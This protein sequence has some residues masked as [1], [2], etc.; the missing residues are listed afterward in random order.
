MPVIRCGKRKEKKCKE[1][2]ECF[3][4]GTTCINNKKVI[5]K[6]P[7]SIIID[8]KVNKNTPIEKGETVKSN[9]NVKKIKKVTCGKR[10]EKTC[11]AVPEYCEW[12]DNKCIPIKINKDEIKTEEAKKIEIKNVK[13]EEPK[14]K[15]ITCGRRKED[16]CNKVPTVCVW[17]KEVKKCIDLL[18]KKPDEPEKQLNIN[19]EVIKNPIKKVVKKKVNVPSPKKVSTPKSSSP[20]KVPSPKSSPS[21]PKVPSPKSSPKVSSPSFP[22]IS[23]PQSKK[24]FEK[25]DNRHCTYYSK[26]SFSPVDTVDIDDCFKTK[27]NPSYKEIHNVHIGQR[28]LL[29]S[30]IQLL[31]KYYE[32]NKKDPVLLYVGAAP[33]THLVLLSFM[34]PKVSFVLYDGAKFDQ[35]LKK[36]PEIF[37]IHEG[38]DGFVTTELINNI[39]HKFVNTNLL[40]VSDIRL[41]DDDKTKFEHGVSRDMQ[42]QEEWMDILKPKMSLLKFRMSYNMNHGD[43]L[44]YTK[45]DILYGIWPKPLSGETR[46]LVRQEDV[47]NKIKYDFKDYEE[48]MFFHNKYERSYCYQYD[49]NET[50][51]VIRDF[52]SSK[53]N[54]YC[55]CFDC[56][57][58]LQILDKYARLMDKNLYFTINQFTHYMNREKKPMFQTKGKII[59]TP[60]KLQPV[61]MSC[62]ESWFNK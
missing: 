53:K 32:E 56:L 4:D 8:E 40:F 52:I 13:A 9:S 46:L 44:T 2:V 18:L 16:S 43:K 49:N 1:A 20:Q 51:K 23:S 38:N 31:T 58:E 27:Y 15:K 35:E 10:K 42:L 39:K 41:G 3:W 14:Q 45:G 22:K 30:E 19:V 55:P 48:V 34:F 54:P 59:M 24:M 5:K 7:A 11:K 36:Y 6:T 60:R 33:G 21:P 28:K 37:E 57:S 25:V 12:S 61:K 29:L 47:G 62:K 50:P 26:D 17:N